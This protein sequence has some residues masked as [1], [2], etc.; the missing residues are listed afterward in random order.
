MI[1]RID[2]YVT[3]GVTSEQ[4]AVSDTL[5]EDWTDTMKDMKLEV[6]IVIGLLAGILL[7]VI[8]VAVRVRDTG[9]DDAQRATALYDL[10]R[11]LETD[12]D[13]WFKQKE[14]DLNT[15]A[16]KEDDSHIQG[17]TKSIDALNPKIK[18]ARKT[19]LGRDN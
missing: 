11:H 16:G 3:S 6:K 17:L 5:P 15:A 10:S 8:V 7:A 4:D 9:L 13:F 12:R 14:N 19:L 1:L 18:S 2:L